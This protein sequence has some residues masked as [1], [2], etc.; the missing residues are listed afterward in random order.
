MAPCPVIRAFR[1][2]IMTA[3]SKTLH[4][5]AVEIRGWL[6]TVRTAN[7]P[8]FPW[9]ARSVEAFRD[10]QNPLSSFDCRATA[11]GQRDEQAP[12]RPY[13]GDPL[14]TGAERAVHRFTIASVTSRPAFYT[15][16][17]G[18]QQHRAARM[19]SA[20]SQG[21]SPFPGR[22][23]AS[24]VPPSSS[25]QL[26]S[27]PELC[28]QSCVALTRPMSLFGRPPA[29]AFVKFLGVGRAI[30]RRPRRDGSNSAPP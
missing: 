21:G 11:K 17:I 10:N 7:P 23:L 14:P 5:A 3:V 19:T 12:G 16:S 25:G 13:G 26:P 2:P 8:A 24:P 9:R 29:G 1:P 18:L 22:P 27:P 28:T 30:R 4:I 15:Y 6:R 20:G